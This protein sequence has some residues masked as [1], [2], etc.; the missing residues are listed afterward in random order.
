MV[1]L[2]TGVYSL[3]Y[4]AQDDSAPYQVLSPRLCKEA[5]AKNRCKFS[6]IFFGTNTDGYK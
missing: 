1:E 3:R 4:G 5:I 2:A 6:A